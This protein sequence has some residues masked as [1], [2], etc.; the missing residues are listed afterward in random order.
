MNSLFYNP[1]LPLPAVGPPC[2]GG[3][4]LL[5]PPLPG[6]PVPGGPPLPLPLAAEIKKT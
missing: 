6:P 4:V 5:G 3:C 1:P 2:Q